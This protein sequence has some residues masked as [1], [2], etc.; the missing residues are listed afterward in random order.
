MEVA[1]ESFVKMIK[2]SQWELLYRKKTSSY[3]IT[4]CHISFLFTPRHI[5]I[6]SW[7]QN[8]NVCVEMKKSPKRALFHKDK[9]TSMSRCNISI[10]VRI[11]WCRA[12][13]RFA[14]SQLEMA[15]LCNDISH[16]LGTS[17]ES[18]M[19]CKIPYKQINT[20]NNT[21]DLCLSHIQLLVPYDFFIA[22]TI[23]CP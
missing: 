14:P 22:L 16:W 17:L 9:M 13:S 7:W 3:W 6:W 4:Q 15:L 10:V 21:I 2:S 19:W 20:V 23:S 18:A 12:D 8:K 11:I 5:A 1:K